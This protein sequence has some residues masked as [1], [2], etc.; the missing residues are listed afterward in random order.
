VLLTG[1]VFIAIVFT[2]K[3]TIDMNSGF[4]SFILG[5][6]LLVPVLYVIFRVSF[7]FR[8]KHPEKTYD[9]PHFDTSH[10]ARIDDPTSMASLD[11]H[12]RRNPFN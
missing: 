7:Y 2:Q 4:I 1:K 9:P 12:Y 8:K 6:V 3:G 5:C 10:Y 11:E